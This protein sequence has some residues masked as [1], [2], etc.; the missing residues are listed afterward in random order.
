MESLKSDNE[1]LLKL[2]RE[3]NEY[4]NW[5]DSEI[6]NSAATKTLTG[7]KGVKESFSAN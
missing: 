5:E 3:T 1:K 2:L 4:A 7:T 6:L